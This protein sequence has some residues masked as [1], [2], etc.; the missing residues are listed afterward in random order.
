MGKIDTHRALSDRVV[1]RRERARI[2]RAIVFQ[3]VVVRSRAVQRKRIVDLLVARARVL[4]RIDGGRRIGRAVVA[5]EARHLD[6][7][8]GIGHNRIRGVLCHAE[9][10]RRRVVGLCQRALDRNRDILLRD[11]AVA[12]LC[13]GRCS[14]EREVPAL[15]C[16]AQIVGH[17]VGRSAVI[18]ILRIVLG[19]GHLQIL[20]NIN[21]IAVDVHGRAVDVLLLIARC[22]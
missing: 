3:I 8:V 10:T 19:R 16:V 7:V 17:A 22:T 12:R 6:Q 1:I 15:P 9:H 21:M 20:Q 13:K 4:V 2:V 11:N 5:R 18:D 14:A